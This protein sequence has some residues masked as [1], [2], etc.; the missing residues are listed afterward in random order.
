MDIALRIIGTPLTILIKAGIK[1]QEVREETTSR[2]LTSQLV[3]IEVTI[4]RQIVYA[5]LFLP[6]LDGKDGR[7]ATSYTLVSRK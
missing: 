6:N 7:L 2:Y 1:I 3:E 5:T 4:L